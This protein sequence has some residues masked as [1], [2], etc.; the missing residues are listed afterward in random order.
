MAETADRTTARLHLRRLT[1]ADVPVVVALHCDPQTNVHRPGGAP[2]PEEGEQAVH[3]FVGGWQEHGVG[4]WAVEV[5]GRVVGVAGVRPLEFR[6]RECWNLYYRFFPDV[7]GKGLA[8]EAAREAVVVADALDPARPVVARTRPTNYPALRV[9]EA[10][11]L[12]RRPDLDGD[13][14][15]VLARGW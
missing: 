2:S 3:E 15:V 7:W 10:A 6:G 5:D 13:G 8:V 1:T 14:F 12:G 4:Y 9:A 11:G